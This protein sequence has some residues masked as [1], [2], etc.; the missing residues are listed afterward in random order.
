MT[1]GILRS[2]RYPHNI[3]RKNRPN[4]RVLHTGMS[5][6]HYSGNTG[7]PKRTRKE[8]IRYNGKIGECRISSK[9]KKIRILL[10]ID[11][12]GKRH[13]IDET[14]IKPN[15]EKVKAIL[16]SKHPE[17]QKQLKSFLSAI[18]NLA[19][20]LARLSETTERLRRLL[21]KDSTWNWGKQPDED[22]HNIKKLLTEGPC[23]AHYAKG[24][25]NIV[26]TDASKTGLGVT[27]WQKQSVGEIKPIAFGSRYLN[28][29][30]KINQSGN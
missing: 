6:W 13:E 26:R 30:E 7:W 14:G 22:F 1:E 9:R 24:R 17:N 23:F 28:D 20:C 16:E 3:P 25:E 27:L 8:T 5:G 19:K 11:E 4:T 29:S 12:T 15:K 21:Q 18:Q 2:R 10:E